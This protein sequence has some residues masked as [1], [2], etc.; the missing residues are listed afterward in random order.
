M[1]TAEQ[2]Q[3]QIALLLSIIEDEQQTMARQQAK[4]AEKIQKNSEDPEY[5]QRWLP[6]WM[7]DMDFHKENIA[8]RSN[9]IHLLQWVLGET[10]GGN[11]NE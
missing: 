5:V 9:E 6:T 11:E 1:K 4:I 7:G 3:K 2:I 10:K 8:K